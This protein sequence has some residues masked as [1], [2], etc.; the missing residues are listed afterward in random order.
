MFGLKVTKIGL[1]L[2]HQEP[3]F[4]W[5]ESRDYYYYSLCPPHRITTH[6]KESEN[7]MN[8]LVNCADGV[9]LCFQNIT[10]K[11]ESDDLLNS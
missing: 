5:N 2:A 11:L 8:S 7:F 4:T 9:G 1:W 6:F 3:L 10:V